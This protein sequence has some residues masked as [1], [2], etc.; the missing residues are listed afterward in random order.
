MRAQK[1]VVAH[2]LHLKQR[3]R[4]VKLDIAL[5]VL[6]PGQAEFELPNKKSARRTDKVDLGSERIR[7]MVEGKHP[8]T[9]TTVHHGKKLHRSTAQ[10]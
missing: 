3:T 6:I 10:K 4:T 2:L 9:E 7:G 8:V 5:V 1:H